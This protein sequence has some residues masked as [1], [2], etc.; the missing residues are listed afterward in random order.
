MASEAVSLFR[1]FY[2]Q[3][4]PDAP[5]PHR[6]VQARARKVSFHFILLVANVR[7][8]LSCLVKESP[9][10]FHCCCFRELLHLYPPFYPQIFY[11]DVI[12]LILVI[13]STRRKSSR[14]S[15][16]NNEQFPWV[17]VKSSSIPTP[18]QLWEISDGN[19]SWFV[20]ARWNKAC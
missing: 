14:G 12:Q 8:V 9:Q 18:D 1:S 20:L 5:E 17:A 6:T 7:R 10:S 19:I 13:F 15:V 2:D 11:V 3:G 16:Q 4:N